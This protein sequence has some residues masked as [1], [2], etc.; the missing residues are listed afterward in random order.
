MLCDLHHSYR[1]GLAQI[2]HPLG[3]LDF[4]RWRAKSL[5]IKTSHAGLYLGRFELRVGVLD[6]SYAGES[7]HPSVLELA[8]SGN[9]RAIAYWLNVLLL[10]HQPLCKSR[11]RSSVWL[12][13]GAR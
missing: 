11:G 8:R 5:V 3:S 13:A 1:S 2:S 7:D 10:P 12:F 6:M 4:Q 9:F